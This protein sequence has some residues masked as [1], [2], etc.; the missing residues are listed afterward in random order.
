MAIEHDPIITHERVLDNI[1]LEGQY[2]YST[3]TTIGLTKQ[4]DFYIKLDFIGLDS[5]TITDVASLYEL[6]KELLFSSDLAKEQ[7]YD[8]THIVTE[9]FHSNSNYAMTWECL[10]DKPGPS[11]IIE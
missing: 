10:S 3:Y 9:K 2:N 11:L 4:N 8:I 7:G 5:N 6:N 1:I